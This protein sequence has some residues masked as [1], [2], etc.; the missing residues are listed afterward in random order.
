MALIFFN[1]DS[2]DWPSAYVR[3]NILKPVL[4]IPEKHH[5]EKLRLIILVVFIVNSFVYISF[6]TE[7]WQKIRT[8]KNKMP[9]KRSSQKHQCCFNQAAPSPSSLRGPAHSNPWPWGF[10][11]WDFGGGWNKMTTWQSVNHSLRKCHF[12]ALWNF[13]FSQKPYVLGLATPEIKKRWY[14][15]ASILKGR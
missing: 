14:Q 5:C 1:A 9:T 8:D 15:P 12:L 3:W 13:G 11:S 2:L 10:F 4:E 6:L 7:G